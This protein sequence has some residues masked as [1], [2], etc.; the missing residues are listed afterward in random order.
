MPFN[1]H[2]AEGLV[3]SGLDVLSVSLDGARQETYEKYRVRG[4]MTTVIE[5]IRLVNQAKQRVNSATPKLIWSFLAFEHNVDDI[6]QAKE[7]A[8][9]L[10]MEFFVSKGWIAGPDWESDGRVSPFKEPGV[11]RCEMLWERAI[12]HLTAVSHLAMARSTVKMTMV[13]LKAAVSGMFGTTRRF[14]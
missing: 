6:D 4:N 9:E 5:N 7:I 13:P 11:D 3:A 12:V 14:V 1:A 8:Q 10:G 2:R